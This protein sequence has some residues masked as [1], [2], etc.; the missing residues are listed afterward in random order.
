MAAG[1]CSS[2]GEFCSKFKPHLIMFVAQIGYSI[3]YFVT[4]ACFNQGMDP[5]V[6]VTYRH[7]VGGLAVFPFAYVLE[8]KVRPKLTLYLFM[9]IFALSAFGVSLNVNMFF[10]GMTYTSPAFVTSMLNTIASLTFVIAIILR[11]EIVDIRN[12]RGIAKVLGTIASLA[13]VMTITLYQGPELKSLWRAPMHI[14]KNTV[15]ENWIKGSILSVAGCVSWA[16]WF[17]MQ[18]MTLKR[19]PAQLSLTAWMNLVGG[20]QSAVFTVFV[21]RKP[22]AWAMTST[23]KFW[24]IMYAGAFCCGFLIFAQL[25]CIEQRGPVFVTM[26]NPLTTILVAIAAYMVLGEKLY[27][28]SIL[29]GVI[30]IIGLYLLLWGK[31]DNQ[32]AHIDSKMQLCSCNV[33]PQEHNMQIFTSTERPEER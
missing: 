3:Q 5:H 22:E 10:I 28:G 6:Y 11:M 33:V 7:T 9:E 13:G 21:Q 24:S 1:A 14:G 2:F 12:P 15:H 29:G 26:F 16:I 27:V 8:R 31:E 4:E 30:V 17:I 19:Y 18:A 32:E 25:W 23:L 20:A